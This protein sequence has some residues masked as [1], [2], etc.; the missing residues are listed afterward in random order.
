[1][2]IKNVDPLSDVNSNLFMLMLD[3]LKFD[4]NND[5]KVMEY[6]ISFDIVKSYTAVLGKVG[7][8][9]VY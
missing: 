1:M 6:T 7:A 2:K 8:K 9:I 4:F 5:K 3:S